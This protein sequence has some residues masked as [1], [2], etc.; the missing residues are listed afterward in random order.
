M[1]EECRFLGCYGTCISSQLSRLLFTANVVPNSPMLVT[2]MMAALSSFEMSV[3][4][5]AARRNIAEHGIIHSHRRE[6]LKSC[7][8]LTA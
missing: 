3:L 7:I 6:N 1:Y 8:A 2:L 4:T 5:R